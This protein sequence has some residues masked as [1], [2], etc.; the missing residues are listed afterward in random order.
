MWRRFVMKKSLKI[1]VSLVLVAA[2]G[3]VCLSGCL[4]FRN[5]ELERDIDMYEKISLIKQYL[6]YYAIYDFDEETAEDSALKYYLL[7]LKDDA[8]A[9]YFNEEE[10]EEFNSSTKGNFIGVGVNV[11]KQ[12]DILEKGLFLYRVLGNSPA[13]EQGLKAGDIITSVNGISLVGMSY[14]DAVDMMLD[15]EGTV[16]ELTVDRDGEN[17]SFSVTRK[18]FVQRYVDYEIIDEI[19]FIRIHGF[20][21]AAKPQFSEALKDLK[22]AGVKGLLFD[23]RNNPGGELNTVTDML[24]MLVPKGEPIIIIEYKQE[25]EITKAKKDPVIEGLPMAVLVNGGSA[26]AS[27]LFSSCLRDVLSVPLVGETTYGKGI[28]Q[29]TFSLGDGSGLKFTTFR[30]FTKSRTDYNGVGLVPDFEVKSTEQQLYGFYVVDHKDDPQMQKALQVLS[31]AIN[32]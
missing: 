18:S 6:D 19:G 4:L 10:M 1:L 12:S 27:E 13:E 17:L 22:N 15:V 5:I 29:T 25:E 16:A 26:S 32:K 23:L 8:Y 11:V 21:E 2:I 14:D 9:Y 30:Y 28:G 3:L 24:D 20:S 31:D 7:G